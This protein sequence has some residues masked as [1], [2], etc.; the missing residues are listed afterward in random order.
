M[1]HSIIILLTALLCGCGG[2][3]EWIEHR[4]PM[5]DEER[6]A[7]AAHELAIIAHTPTTLSGNDQ[8]WDDAIKAAHDVAQKT[9][10]KPRL[11]EW[12][13]CGVI[14]PRSSGY[15]GRWKEVE[16]VK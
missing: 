2:H 9:W 1:K 4:Q 10:C 3:Y 8:D 15:T 13:A 16:Q 5:T 12:Y 11:F 14:D 7:T 6:C